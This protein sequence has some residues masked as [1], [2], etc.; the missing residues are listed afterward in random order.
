MFAV[1][2]YCGLR[3][4]EYKSATIEDG[5]VKVKNSKRK[6]GAIE[7]KYIPITPVFRPYIGDLEQIQLYTGKSLRIKFK[8]VFGDKHILYDLRTTFN[9]WLRKCHV[10][11]LARKEFMGHSLPAL[12]KAYTDFSVDFARE[13]L[14]NEGEKF[15][16]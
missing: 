8:N 7:Y 10:D 15:K 16:Y 5:F 12:D 4:G 9:T 2:L 14:K 6:H 13:Y 11:D 1:V 3:P